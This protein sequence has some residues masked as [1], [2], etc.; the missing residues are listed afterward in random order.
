MDWAG[1]IKA[2]LS[3]LEKILPTL[4]IFTVGRKSKELENIKDENENLKKYQ[5]IDDNSESSADD[6]YTAGLWK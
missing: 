3:F 4:A 1:A 5:E 6:A 2:I